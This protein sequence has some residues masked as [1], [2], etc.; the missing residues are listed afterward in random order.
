VTCPAHQGKCVIRA[1]GICCSGQFGGG[2]E[3]GRLAAFSYEAPAL[4]AGG[5]L[6]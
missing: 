3:A 4:A 5:T 6:T 1:E 2:F